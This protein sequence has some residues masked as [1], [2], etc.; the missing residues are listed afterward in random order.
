MYLYVGSKSWFVCES[1]SRETEQDEKKVRA[2]AGEI[3]IEGERRKQRQ[4]TE[5]ENIY[6]K[7]VHFQ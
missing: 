2:K 6:R 4:R 5:R 7:V 3:Q 1:C